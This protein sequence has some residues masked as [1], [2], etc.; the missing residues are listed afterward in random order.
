MI[1]EIITVLFFIR[2][3]NM[4]LRLMERRRDVLYYLSKT[5]RL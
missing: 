4:L 5:D 1:V 2:C 3:A